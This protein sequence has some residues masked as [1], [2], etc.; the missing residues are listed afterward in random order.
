[1]GKLRSSAGLGYLAEWQ[2]ALRP[3]VEGQLA[4]LPWTNPV[5]DIGADGFGFV[6]GFPRRHVRFWDEVMLKDHPE[7]GTFLSLLRDGVG[8]DDLLVDTH[9]GPYIDRPYKEE[10]FRGLVMRNRITQEFDGFVS[11]EVQSFPPRGCIAK[12][13][14]VKT[15]STPTRPRMIMPLGVEPTK[16]RMIYDARALNR[17]TKHR[18][19]P[20]DTVGGVAY[21]AS[22][23]CFVTSLDDSSA[24]HHL[25]LRPSLG[26]CS[27][28]RT[29]G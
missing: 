7:R 21:V 18:P 14:D 28:S 22:Q 17:F 10:L 16:P 23:G 25:L 11:A 9:R 2:D 15:A 26:R 29:K 19:F 5:W 6:P 27:V 3:Y 1:M 4:R 24:F 13:A 20:M 12:W 8:M